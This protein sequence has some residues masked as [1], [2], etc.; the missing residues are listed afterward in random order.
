MQD[1]LPT[2]FS[3]NLFWDV[4]PATLDLDRHEKYVIARVL[5]HGTFADWKLLCRRFTLPRIVEVARTLRSLDPKARSFL[6]V[7]GQTPP[8][9]FRCCTLKSSTPS[10]WNC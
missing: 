5:E 3:T 1:I 10:S 6:A 9:S 4:D 8:E 2:D 7:V